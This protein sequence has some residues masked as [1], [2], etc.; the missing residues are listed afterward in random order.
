MNRWWDKG[1]G[2]AVSASMY[3]L[4]DFSGVKVLAST[5]FGQKNTV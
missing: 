3:M 5:S 2:A 4:M 1:G